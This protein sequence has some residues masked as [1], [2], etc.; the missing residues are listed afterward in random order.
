MNSDHS[1]EPPQK[2]GT[3]LAVAALEQEGRPDVTDALQTREWVSKILEQ[4]GWHVLPVDIT[5][6]LLSSTERTASIIR[7]P[8]AECIFNLF[9]GFGSDSGAEHRF[10]A[11]VE[12]EGIPCTGNPAS[13]LKACLSKGMTAERLTQNKVPV[14]GGITLFPGLTPS[15]ILEKLR[16]PVFLKPLSED[17][18]VGINGGSLVEKPEQLEEAVLSRLADFPGGIRA[19]EFLPGREYSVSCM[20]NGPYRPVGVSVIDY[21][22]MEG[23]LQYLDYGSKW[24]PESPLYDLTPKKAEGE[25]ARMAR[26]LADSAGK[27]L[28]CRGY[29]RVDL[30]EK[31]DKLFVIDVNPNPDLSTSGGFMRQCRE[32]GMSEL[33]AVS[34]IVELALEKARRG[35]CGGKSSC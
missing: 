3:I 33:D 1:S 21:G 18:S 35:A 31:D 2:R 7:S 25:K 13:A 11:I 12:K 14:P 10:M 34:E 4:A 24:D 8:G 32:S 30:R 5:P 20:G 16:L 23:C 9:E 27:A 29:F 22:N 6:K 19:E 15:V 28:G 17:G 26:E